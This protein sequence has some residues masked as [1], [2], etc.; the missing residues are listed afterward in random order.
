MKSLG[1]KFFNARN[2]GIESWHLKNVNILSLSSCKIIFLLNS[3]NLNFE[4]V[5]DSKHFVSFC[6]TWW[7]FSFVIKYMI[8]TDLSFSDDPP[9]KENTVLLCLLSI[10]VLFTIDVYS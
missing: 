5:F 8:L 7:Q 10:V 3:F 2:F 1:D 9:L 4:C 6:N